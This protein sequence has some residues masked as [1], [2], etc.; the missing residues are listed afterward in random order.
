MIQ[1]SWSCKRRTTNACCVAGC[2]KG[3]LAGTNSMRVPF[4]AV[5]SALSAK[6]TGS[7]HNNRSAPG[8]SIAP[9]SSLRRTQCPES[10]AT[11][12]SSAGKIVSN[13]NPRR[14]VKNG[15]SSLMIGAG[16]SDF[17]TDDQICAIIMFDFAHLVPAS[18]SFATPCASWDKDDQA[19]NFAR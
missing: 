13:R 15:K 16:Q 5:S 1:G 14:F 4:S 10:T 2:S 11:A 17:S 18:I 3:G 6:L 19:Y 8:A 12:G 9:R 7:E